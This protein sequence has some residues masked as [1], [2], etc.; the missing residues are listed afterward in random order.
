MSRAERARAEHS[1]ASLRAQM[2]SFVA[3]LTAELEQVSLVV[4][5][6][7]EVAVRV[8][9]VLSDENAATATIVQ[10]VGLEPVLAGRV[11]CMANAAAFGT[12]GGPVTD[13]RTAV[14]QL[15]FDALRSVVL[16]Y[17]IGQLRAAKELAPI[18]PALRE[19]WQE[20]VLTASLSSILARHY[21]AADPETAMLAGAVQGVGKLYILIKLQRFPLLLASAGARAE[22]N[23]AWHA[24]FGRALLRQWDM[25]QVIADA[26]GQCEHCPQAPPAGK[27]NLVA[28]LYLSTILAQNVGKP[29]ALAELFAT[30]QALASLGVSCA[31]LQRLVAESEGAIVAIMGS[32]GM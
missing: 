1:G 14:T 11:L 3:E 21:G 15:G 6:Y 30:D 23:E 19:L 12:Q 32:L 8:Q 22:L 26:V 17:A 4:P 25:P 28:V 5:G 24:T 31:E 10:S 9:Q 16:S 27:L 7:P 18:A 29:A 20:S 13:V 2:E